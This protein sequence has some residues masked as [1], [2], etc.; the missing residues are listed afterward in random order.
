MENFRKIVFSILMVC[1]TGCLALVQGIGIGVTP[2]YAA[3]NSPKLIFVGDSR[4]V[5]MRNYLRT[6]DTYV[7]LG[8][9]GYNW[10]V[11]TALPEVNAVKKPGDIIVFNFGVNDLYQ[12]DNYIAEMNYLIENDWADCTVYYMSVNPVNDA[13]TATYGGVTNAGVESFNQ[14]LINGLSDKIRWIDTYSASLGAINTD[15]SKSDAMG[16]HYSADIYQLYYDMVQQRIQ[17]DKEDEIVQ[18]VMNQVKER[19]AIMMKNIKTA[20]AVLD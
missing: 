15:A 19:L 18:R 4:T 17:S 12:I 8:S 9:M 20:T 1:I 16:V 3:E 14:A 5:Q 6:N 7:C 2:V 10:F 11:S 13:K